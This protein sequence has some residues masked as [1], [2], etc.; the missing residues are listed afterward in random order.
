V[1]LSTTASLLLVLTPVAP[2]PAG[3]LLGD[4]AESGASAHWGN[5]SG[6]W[7][8]DEGVYFATSQSTDPPACSSVTAVSNLTDFVVEFDVNGVSDGGVFLRSRLCEN[9]E[10]GAGLFLIGGWHGSYY[11]RSAYLLC[12]W[13][14]REGAR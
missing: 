7:F 6:D 13:T 8:A 2:A 9:G 4:D 10:V 11:G 3:L 1:K 14:A 12:R 5:E